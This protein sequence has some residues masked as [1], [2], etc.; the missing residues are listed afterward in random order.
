M[1]FW[2]QIFPFQL[3]AS[4]IEMMWFIS[5]LTTDLDYNQESNEKELTND[6]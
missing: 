1:I 6:T 4:C 2:S 5:S 3:D